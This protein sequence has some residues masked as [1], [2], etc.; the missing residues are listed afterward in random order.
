[1][2]VPGSGGIA[3]AAVSGP[4]PITA[5]APTNA[6]SGMQ[7]NTEPVNIAGNTTMTRGPLGQIGQFNNQYN[8][9]FDNEE[10]MRRFGG[11]NYA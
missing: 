6:V 7:T 10:Y 8:K 11:F 4:E 2:F 5:E 1:M 9:P 3:Q